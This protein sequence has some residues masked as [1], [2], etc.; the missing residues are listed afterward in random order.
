MMEINKF[1]PKMELRQFLVLVIPGM[2]FSFT[3]LYPIDYKLSCYTLL[4][5]DFTSVNLP[6]VSLL[7]FYLLTS[8]LVF[9]IIFHFL[10]LWYFQR[11]MRFLISKFNRESSADERKSPAYE[12]AEFTEI[13]LKAVNIDISYKQVYRT[14]FGGLS[15][16]TLLSFFVLLNFQK[17]LVVIPLILLCFF[18]SYA[19]YRVTEEV[20]STIEGLI[21]ELP[22]FLNDV[23]KNYP[24]E[25]F[26]N[27]LKK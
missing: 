4:P 22:N 21:E 23:K 11:F 8:G 26:K 18:S 19:A 25:V 15:I 10:Y 16:S 9:G 7:I 6:Y 1:V 2:I 20:D 14:F 5:A 27:L 12:R 24:E 13:L 17:L 3:I